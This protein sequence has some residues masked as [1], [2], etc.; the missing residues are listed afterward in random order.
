MSHTGVRYSDSDLQEFKTL[1]EEK[2]VKSRQEVLYVQEQMR[3]MNENSSN[4]QSGDWTDESTSHTEMEM[5]NSM[6]ARH[7]QFIRNLETALIRIQNKTYGICSVTGQ[8]IDKKRLLLVPHATK[9]VEGKN[10][11]PMVSGNH[12]TNEAAAIRR[13]QEEEEGIPNDGIEARNYDE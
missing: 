3:E 6:L 9:S 11:R 1:I 13:K 12:A 2:L 7:T 4:Q 5:L 10:T 8:L